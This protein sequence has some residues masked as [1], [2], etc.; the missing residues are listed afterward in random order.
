VPCCKGKI[1]YQGITV[2]G[3]VPKRRIYPTTMQ[4]ADGLIWHL[5][6][7][8]SKKALTAVS[9]KHACS[10]IRAPSPSA[11]NRSFISTLSLLYF[12]LFIKGKA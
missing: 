5:V 4:F 1:T 2:N 7:R 9:W 8:F 3:W 11:N 12:L 10:P 6:T